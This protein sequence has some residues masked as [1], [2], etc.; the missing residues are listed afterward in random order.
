MFKNVLFTGVI[1][2]L[3][4]M[5]MCASTSARA[6]ELTN[7]FY[8]PEYSMIASTTSL[9]FDKAQFKGQGYNARYYRKTLNEDVAIGL[10]DNLSIIGS[11]GNVWDR[12]NF[13]GGKFETSNS[14]FD[15]TIGAKYNVLSYNLIRVQLQGLYGQRES[16]ADVPHQGTYKYFAAGIKGGLDLNAFMP[17]ASFNMEVPVFQGHGPHNDN[18]YDVKFGGYKMI[19]D[20]YAVDAGFRYNY[21]RDFN[22]QSWSLDAEVSYAF[23]DNLIASVYGAYVL[24][25]D[26]KDDYTKHGQLL[27]IRLRTSF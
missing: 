24:D 6:V 25:G 27:G 23:T 17:Y 2:G 7:P 26:I 12:S 10:A 21:H 20:T 16:W 9:Q 8:L 11:L 14:N 22:V 4:A 19:D 13:A 18:I 15:F 1:A 5:V 3:S